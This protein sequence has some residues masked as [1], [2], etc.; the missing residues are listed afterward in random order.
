VWRGSGN[1]PK[2]SKINPSTSKLFSNCLYILRFL[3]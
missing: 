2:K 3:Y 1:D